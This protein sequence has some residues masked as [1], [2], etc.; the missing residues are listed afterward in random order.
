MARSVGSKRVRKPLAH[1]FVLILFLGTPGLAPEVRAQTPAPPPAQ[2][3]Q[4]QPS[5]PQQ[6]KPPADWLSYAGD[7][8]PQRQRD[9]FVM[10]VDGTDK[11]QITH[12]FN[13]WFASWSPDG[14]RLAVT[15]EG[16]QLYTLKPDGSDLKLITNGAFSPGF[17]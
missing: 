16:S 12:G 2:Q 5:P 1:L 6:A 3:P 17:W 15:T 13:V 11:K 8:L 7:I 4:P 14:K 10:R 9:L